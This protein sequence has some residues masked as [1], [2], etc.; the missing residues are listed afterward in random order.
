MWVHLEYMLMRLVMV[1]G[2]EKKPFLSK[3]V[4]ICLPLERFVVCAHC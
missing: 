4:W 2:D 1:S 3:W